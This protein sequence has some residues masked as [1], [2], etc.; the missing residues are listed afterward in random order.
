MRILKYIFL[1]ILLATIAI[2]VYVATQKSEFEITRSV[3]INVPR[4]VVYNYVN[5][6]KNWEDWGSWKE[7]DAD[8]KFIYA[9][10]T[11]G[12]GASYS[13]DGSSDGKMTT[14]F[15]RQNDSIVQKAVVSDHNY[16][17]FITFKDTV[18]GTKVTWKAKGSVDFMT[19]VNATFSGGA[20]RL[21]GDLFEQSLYN[22]NKTITKEI[23]TFDIKVNGI[24][25]QGGG[26]YVKK[27]I[28]CL[29]SEML[30]QLHL[31]LPKVINFFKKTNLKMNG[32]PFVIFDNPDA[33]T[34][35]FAVCAPL[36]EE[37]FVSRESDISVEFLEPFSAL[38]TT[39][40]GDYSHRNAARSKAMK[41]FNENKMERGSSHEMEIYEITAT[42]NRHPSKWQTAYMIPVKTVPAATPPTATATPPTIPINE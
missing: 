31:Q 34:V 1:L 40:T 42:E 24:V 10:N 22:L 38:K 8:M 37:I 7:G 30:G 28:V 41:Y 17:S 39:L 18:G 27:K 25:Q 23:N 6:Y 16:D 3:V 26:F 33:D 35:H 32:K 14:L 11:V 12:Q 19:K 5:D 29:K 36:K 20:D 13:W 15:A 4:T 9:E 2:T 21:M